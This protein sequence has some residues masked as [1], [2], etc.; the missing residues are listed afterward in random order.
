MVDEKLKYIGIVS[1]HFV[2]NYG[3]M[4]QV[5][6]TQQ[7]ISNFGIKNE[8]INMTTFLPK[9]RSRQARFYL[10]NIYKKDLLRKIFR[11]TKRKFAKYLNKGIKIGFLSR[12]EAFRRFSLEHFELSKPC[13][14]AEL[15]VF[16]KKYSDVLLGSDQLWLPQNIA[17]DYYTLSFVPRDINSVTYATSFGV[18]DL[19]SCMKPETSAFLSRI[20]HLSVREDTGACLVKNLTGRAAAVV[21]DPTI[22]LTSA[23]WQEYL[24]P[25]RKSDEPYIFCYF[26]GNNPKHRAFANELK[27]KTGLKI[28][29]LRHLDEYIASDEFFGDEAPYDVDPSDFVNY[30]RHASYV[31]T[32][33]FHATVFSILNSVQ[34]FVFM[35]FRGKK[36]T[37][38]TNSRI[39]TLISL[40]GLENR[41]VNDINQ[42]NSLLSNPISY[43]EVDKRLETARAESVSYLKNALG[44]L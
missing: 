2:H 1:C 42:M 25:T 18:S 7:V 14:I 43:K 17:A 11:T 16:C 33:S 39:G 15:P 31:C 3:S 35:R 41:L 6:A 4:L 29:T 22:L 36:N 32:D 26:L 38:S 19:P 10:K 30:I 44:I 37:M 34:F 40:T 12:D 9:L 20:M 27:L 23:Q 8:T 24:P 21:C 13:N 5:Y 28:V